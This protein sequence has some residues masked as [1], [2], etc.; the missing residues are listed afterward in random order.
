MLVQF[1]PQI[2]RLDRDVETIWH[3]EHC[4]QSVIWS[5]VRSQPYSSSN[6]AIRV[7][8]GLSILNALLY[9]HVPVGATNRPFCLQFNTA[10][11][12]ALSL[13]SNLSTNPTM[14]DP[15]PRQRIRIADH[16]DIEA[17]DSCPSDFEEDEEAGDASDISELVN[18]GT[19][20]ESEG[21]PEMTEFER[22]QEEEKAKEAEAM[23]RYND[24]QNKKRKRPE[25]VTSVGDAPEPDYSTTVQTSSNIP[26]P[27][28]IGG[29]KKVKPTPVKP[30]V[31]T[32]RVYGEGETFT[33][34]DGEV[35]KV[36]CAARDV[37][38]A[39]T[40][41][42]DKGNLDYKWG[43]IKRSHYHSCR[44]AE[45]GQEETPVDVF[46][47][48]ESLPPT[49]IRY[50][51]A[52]AIE[53]DHYKEKTDKE[54]KERK[55]KIM[56]CNNVQ[57]RGPKTECVVPDSLFQA[58]VKREVQTK[59]NKKKPTNTPLKETILT[60]GIAVKL[61][62]M[63]KAWIDENSGCKQK[64]IE[65]TKWLRDIES[66]DARK[67]HESFPSGLAAAIVMM[68]VASNEKLHKLV[69]AKD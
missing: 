57:P 54:Y 27:A 40:A 10:A 16:L 67:W 30:E 35:W 3:E 24:K 28:R 18:S 17:E 52:N 51:H 20:S 21:E 39:P 61:D 34:K 32:Y 60:S 65:Y 26:A 43:Y 55:K 47:M 59:E 48:S 15:A 5:W 69:L 58:W 44:R 19:E 8:L 68:R 4:V 64:M 23:K 13:R 63:A 37:N 49:L 53:K 29:K 38:P 41:N 9:V 62:E 25:S 36:F 14:T 45:A 1:E 6:K 31:E 66:L 42:N 11:R 2:K 46:L 7:E 56:K 33:L 50:T 12:Q 22:Q